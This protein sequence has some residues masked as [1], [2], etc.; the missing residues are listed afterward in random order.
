MECTSES[1]LWS[2][3]SEWCLSGTRMHVLQQR[4]RVKGELR[5]RISLWG[6]VEAT[7]AMICCQG[8]CIMHKKLK[9]L[10]L[11]IECWMTCLSAVQNLKKQNFEKYLSCV[12]PNT[13]HTQDLFQ[14]GQAAKFTGI[15]AFHLNWPSARCCTV[16]TF[17]TI[18]FL[19]PLIRARL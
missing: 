2:F 8:W 9:N 18:Y 4:G 11:E 17:F 15:S 1:W 14:K 13:Q 19:L 5:R 10:E 6:I 7:E 12:T 16:R 3:Y